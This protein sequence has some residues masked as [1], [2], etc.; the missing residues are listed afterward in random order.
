[1][2]LTDR[3]AALVAEYDTT[4]RSS[5]AISL[6]E[7]LGWRGDD[8]GIVQN[9]PNASTANGRLQECR[10]EVVGTPVGYVFVT[11]EMPQSLG[12][13]AA[14]VA[15]NSGVDWAIVTNFATTRL[16]CARWSSNQ[17]LFSIKAPQYRAR[18]NELE[19]LSPGAIVSGELTRHA[20]RQR[21]E[22]D[23][24]QPIDEHLL[25]RMQAWRR[26]LLRTSAGVSGV[27]DEQIHELIGRLLFIRSCEDRGI[28][29][30]ELLLERLGD[31]SGEPSLSNRLHRLFTELGTEF[32]S[33][34]FPSTS[35]TAVHFDD[36]SLGEII[37]ELYRP[38]RAPGHY[39]Y[40]F[41][42]LNVDV[43]GMVYQRYVA[44]VLEY[45][46]RNTPQLTL[47]IP[48]LPIGEVTT[49][50]R[51][52]EQGTYFTPTPL[53]DYIATHVMEPLLSA[54][55]D[56]SSFPTVADISCGSGAF[57]VG[58]AERMVRRA[59]EFHRRSG[60]DNLYR[61]LITHLRG[62][63]IDARA[64]TLARVNLWI[65]AT[66]GEPPRP[67]PELGTFVLEGDGLFDPALDARRNQ[68]D[69]VIGNPPFRSIAGIPQETQSLLRSRYRSAVGRFDLAYVFLER[70]LELVRPGG[71]VGFI[72][73]NR[74]FTNSD[75][76]YL[77]EVLSTDAVI[78]RVVDL[79]DQNAFS[80][81]LS[82]VAILILRKRLPDETTDNLRVAVHRIRQLTEHPGLQLRQGDLVA[83][84]GLNDAYSHVFTTPHPNGGGPWIWS[85][86]SIEDAIE[87]KL[88]SEATDLDDIAIVR[89]GVKT[90]S[91]RIF[92]FEHLRGDPRQ[93]LW[94]LRN[95][96][97]VEV[98]LEPALLRPS[99]HGRMIERFG[100]P[101][102]VVAQDQ[103]EYVLY[104]YV[105]RRLLTE[106]E[107]RTGYPATYSYLQRYRSELSN[108]STVRRGGIWYDLSW[109]RNDEWVDAPKLIAPV[110]VLNSTWALD[111]EGQY[112]PI[113][114]TAV[115]QRDDSV[116]LGI[117]TAVLNSSIFN[118]YLRRRAAS[119]QS[120]YL[121]IRTR[122]VRRFRF[123]WQLVQV[124]ALLAKRLQDLALSAAR[125]A[126]LSLGSEREASE[127]DLILYD[128]LGLTDEQQR[129]CAE[130]VR[131]VAAP[132]NQLIDEHA[133]LAV[134]TLAGLR[135]ELLALDE[136]TGDHR[137]RRLLELRN[138][139]RSYVEQQMDRTP[140]VPAALMRLALVA[141]NELAHTGASSAQ[142][143]LLA[144]LVQSAERAGDDVTVI[145]SYV[146]QLRSVDVNVGP[147]IRAAS[148][149]MAIEPDEVD[150]ES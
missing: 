101:D 93:G 117:F 20:D 40:D 6:F 109:A 30:T 34:L 11:A 9:A 150:D 79:T 122:D 119:F 15:Y 113:G 94:I 14:N 59:R 4:R 49:H 120:G 77:R 80:G 95:G 130:S 76:K 44:T 102:A 115:A 63:D 139:L 70:A 57:L 129:L 143:R 47:P 58:V 82:Y 48:E 16:L 99:T 8:F 35:S 28:V 127:I 81:A 112:L 17:T 32:D 52:R 89:Q 10:L 27:S 62:I 131:S 38:V 85:A 105:G 7:E 37:R 86:S 50:S 29:P 78:E 147:S 88:S 46:T 128:I 135:D 133:S 55:V 118:W 54:N 100:I 45:S 68:L 5:L 114:G 123:P 106:F 126:Q 110:L 149:T 137:V 3:L 75:A 87:Q 65:L 33:E 31:T 103:R 39:R 116:P 25:D 148:R 144:S 74:V 42:Y 134:M 23:V 138:W 51:Q 41:S 91:N 21:G 2:S 125:S 121:E 36:A 90:G 107:L 71:R 1:M 19:L 12:H 98:R 43:L 104:P 53:V 72:L 108:R 64:V 26:M 145:G 13:H 84:E 66:M 124:D 92:L 141:S 61:A 136:S 67:L 83:D 73:P 140:A 97:G 111:A 56:L 60:H 24:L 69:A 142:L 96:D 132:P 22:R 146:R 18:V